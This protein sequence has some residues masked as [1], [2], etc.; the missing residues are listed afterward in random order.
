VAE[1][2]VQVILIYTLSTQLVLSISP[3]LIGSAAIFTI[4]WTFSYARRVPATVASIQKAQ[5]I[6]SGYPAHS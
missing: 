1:L 5:P 3:V 6:E 2:V 4:I